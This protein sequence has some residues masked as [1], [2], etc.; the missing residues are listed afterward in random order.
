MRN[1]NKIQPF[2]DSSRVQVSAAILDD[3]RHEWADFTLFMIASPSVGAG[4]DVA[5][6][7][8]NL[9]TCSERPDKVLYLRTA[10]SESRGSSSYV[11]ILFLQLNRVAHQWDIQEGYLTV[12]RLYKDH[13]HR[14]EYKWLKAIRSTSTSQA[15]ARQLFSVIF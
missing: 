9:K 11:Q 13:A 12:L 3:H 1:A 6:Y 7:Q 4:P 2:P 14:L 5:L 15:I 10:I 8:K